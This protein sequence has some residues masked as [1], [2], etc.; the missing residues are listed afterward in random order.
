MGL[1]EASKLL[2][3]G[4]ILIVISF[5]SIE[6]KIIK[7]FFRLDSNLKENSSRY[8]PVKENNFG[9]FN[10]KLKK[11]L[12]PDQR[13]INQ[14]INSRSAKLRYG[15]RSDTPFFYSKEFEGKFENYLRLEKGRS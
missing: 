12:T 11:P 3:E 13:E 6:D 4:G 15:V 2:P 7:N 8:L 14:N 5:H 9:L 1:I 10:L